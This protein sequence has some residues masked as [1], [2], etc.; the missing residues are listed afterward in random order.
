MA[1]QGQYPSLSPPTRPD[2]RG[3]DTFGPDL[4]ERLIENTEVWD[5][6]TS[7]GLA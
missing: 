6:A 2:S 5:T 7:D 4:T 3:V 1:E